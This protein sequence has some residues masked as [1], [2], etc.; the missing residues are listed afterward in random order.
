LR[1]LIVVP[2]FN[3]A[4]SIRFVVEQLRATLPDCD[5][6]VIDDGSTDTTVHQ[7]P[8]P[9]ARC[10]SLPF[11]Q[12]IGGAMQT[13]YRYAYL[14]GYDVVVQC[15]GDGQHP[16]S[17]VHRLLD[18]LKSGQ[19][20]LVIGSRFLGEDSYKPSASRMTGIRVL[21]TLIRALCGQRVTDCTSGFRA[22][23][24]RVITCF[25]H[26]YPEDYPE[27]EV[28]LLLR[29]AGYRIDEVPV[30]MNERLAGTTSI[31]LMRGLF[32]V[33]K[34]STALVLDMF[35]DPWPPG[36]KQEPWSTSEP[37]SS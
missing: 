37:S 11:N 7:V 5:V 21:R 25:A 19:V 24:R 31:P 3:E 20:D 14:N 30:T 16:A 32:Y 10:V 23:N 9:A 1:C 22:A 33:V 35:R 26:W 29:R 8:R 27:P 2:A 13:G 4:G 18:R 12:G 15:D 36:K 6:L 17:Q 34:V 28:V